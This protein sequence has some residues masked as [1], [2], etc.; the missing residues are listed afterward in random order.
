MQHLIEFETWLED[1]HQQYQGSRQAQDKE[2]KSQHSWRVDM[3]H[4]WCSVWN[5][6]YFHN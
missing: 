4:I 6:E 5:L 3:E 2:S 1:W